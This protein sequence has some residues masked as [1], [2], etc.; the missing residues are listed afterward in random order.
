MEGSSPRV[1]ASA[2]EQAALE[3]RGGADKGALVHALLSG[4]PSRTLRPRSNA[5]IKNAPESL[6]PH[7]AGNSPSAPPSR[8]ETAT[9]AVEARPFDGV[10]PAP[11][12]PDRDALVEAGFARIAAV[13]AA[14]RGRVA[15]QVDCHSRFRRDELGRLLARV[16]ELGVSWLEEPTAEVEEAHAALAALRE[17]GGRLGVRLVGA[18]NV[19]GLAAI[20][21]FLARACYDVVMPDVLLAGGP[22]EVVRIGHLAAGLGTAVSL[23]NP[24]GPVMDAHSLHAAAAL[25]Q[26]HL[27]ERQFRE[28][29]LYDAVV[30][31]RDFGLDAGRL[32]VPQSAGVGL[33]VDVAHDAVLL[34]ASLTVDL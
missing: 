12:G 30:A 10:T 26:F 11:D 28:S 17:A 14:V 3:P 9:G 24:S 32:P 25:P 5:N 4:A 33:D 34:G 29:G 19:A 27:L 15:I 31:R 13:A 23:H 18:E 16:A 20:L 1:V 22:A 2:L 7:A 21:P 8:R 6:S